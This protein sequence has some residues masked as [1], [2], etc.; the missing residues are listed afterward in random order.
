MLMPDTRT[1]YK[2][3][4]TGLFVSEEDACANPDTTYRTTVEVPDATQRDTEA[5]LTEAPL[6]E[7]PDA[8]AED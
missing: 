4:V 1:H 5:P 6:T 2:S 7:A 8:P 3:S